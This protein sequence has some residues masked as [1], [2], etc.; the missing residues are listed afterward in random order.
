MLADAGPGGK[1][2]D[3]YHQAAAAT[4]QSDVRPSGESRALGGLPRESP[5][6]PVIHTARGPA[7]AT[8]DGGA[9]GPGD[10]AGSPGA[11]FASS[12]ARA[13]A[14]GSDSE[15]CAPRAVEITRDILTRTAFARWRA[16]TRLAQSLDGRRRRTSFF[17]VRRSWWRRVLEDASLRA[18]I[19][20]VL[21]RLLRWLVSGRG[22]G[23]VGAALGAAGTALLLEG[24]AGAGT[25][26]GNATA[27]RPLGE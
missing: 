16:R 2:G 1:R 11:V 25:T 27:T 17:A 9:V 22:A 6:S 8:S 4:I 21:A 5:P 10:G 14:P 18:A 7:V 19:L 15:P 20:R 13:V 23:P 26:G 24:P 3:R 12:N